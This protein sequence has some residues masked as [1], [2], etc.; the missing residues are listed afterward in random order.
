[1]FERIFASVNDCF[2]EDESYKASN[3]LLGDSSMFQ[4]LAVQSPLMSVRL[5]S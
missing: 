3:V 4:S 5:K 1:M 2:I